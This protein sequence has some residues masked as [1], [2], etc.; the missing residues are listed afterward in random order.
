MQLNEEFELFSALVI[1]GTIVSSMIGFRNPSYHERHLF[2]VPEV[3]AGKQYY[4]LVTSSFLH[5]DWYHLLLNMISL[6]LFGT[7]IERFY[8][9]GQFLLIYFVSVI[10][11]DL[12]S[13][14]I[15]RHHEYR[16]HGA[17]GGVCGLMF[18][19]IFL[20]PGGSMASFM[21]PIP[22][23]SWLYALLFLIASIV[24]MK[25]QRDNIGHDAH[26]GGAIIGMLTT[27]ALHPSAVRE[28]LYL[29]CAI[30]AIATGLFIYLVVNPMFLPLAAF[31]AVR[32]TRKAEQKSSASEARKID[33]ILEKISREGIHS[34]TPAEKALL[35]R[36]SDKLRRRATSE[37]PRSDL[38]I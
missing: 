12:L 1:V 24:R 13:L 15:H 4:R 10:G 17:S 2:S 28:N 14:W 9:P 29:F 35:D 7:A 19:Y 6:Y 37:K 26:I 38:I 5:A 20:F 27:A 11:G 23:P 16:A 32:E 22:I 3:L 21:F 18:S 31:R 33:A 8:G 34:L 30:T 25:G 36:T